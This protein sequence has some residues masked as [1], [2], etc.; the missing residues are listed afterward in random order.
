MPELIWKVG[1]AQGEGIDSTG[2]IVASTL[3]RLGHYV[4]AYRAFM[5][6]IKGGHTSYKV[7]VADRPV[8]YHGDQLD[9]LIAF[10]QLT[11]DEDAPE[12]RD[13]GIVVADAGRWE[14]NLPTD[15]QIHLLRVPMTAVAKELAGNAVM[16]NMVAVGVSAALLQM[17]PQPFY[18]QVE[19]RFGKKGAEVVELNR[20]LIRRGYEY[21]REQTA[22]LPALALP[23]AADGGNWL[24]SG[25]EAAGL[26]A[27]LGGCRF[28]A[29][30]PITPAT[31]VMY[32][33]LANFPRY[34]GKIIQAE[35][36]IAACNMAIGAGYA[37]VRAMTNTSGPGFS[38]MAEAIGL[39]AIAEVPL[40]I[41]DVQRGGPAT[42]L[43]TKTEQSD[44]Y[45]MLWN[46]HGEGPR[47]VICPT[48]VEEMVYY[49]AEAFNLA[50]IYQCPVIVASDL[51][52]GSSRQGLHRVDLNRIR[53]D[54][55]RLQT[56]EE[57]ALLP[58]DAFHRYEDTH[59]GISPRSIPGHKGGE[60]TALSN[61]HDERG[62]Y[63]IE[64]PA[65]RRRQMEKRFRKLEVAARHMEPWAT[66]YEGPANPDLL[67]IGTGSTR[68][69]IAEAAG[70]LR[71]GPAVLEGKA[72]GGHPEADQA[73]TATGTAAEE[74]RVRVGHLQIRTLSP[75]P[76]ET[77]RRHLENCGQA[78]VVDNNFTAQLQGLITKCCGFHAKLHSCLCYDGNPFTVREIVERAGAVLGETGGL[79]ATTA[80]RPT[81]EGR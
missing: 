28:L 32:W 45:A 42:G 3:N 70:W 65:T 43:P 76:V 4:F 7:R 2:D 23:E 40:V 49:M 37:G 22:G 53:I 59:D 16:K 77:V 17:E 10:D 39:A 29:A 15:R 47:L 38:L 71:G 33:L 51:F 66:V 81:G 61:E 60:Y 19:E 35:D 48:T 62:L 68:A 57:L 72:A 75:F 54:R 27:L 34:G 79:A 69:Q 58:R 63:E 56:A 31:E 13:G 52:L 12:L 44:L 20:E 14:P 24:L 50:E 73:G 64:D 8:Y 26:G 67:L 21:A 5:S 78:L 55:G 6:L 18:R 36:E 80:R 1:G 11:L 25:N 9:L 74:A 30:Y 46:S 41:I